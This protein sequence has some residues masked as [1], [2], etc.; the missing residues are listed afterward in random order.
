MLI[1]VLQRSVV[2]RARAP[3]PAVLKVLL[4][5]LLDLPPLAFLLGWWV[6]CSL[7]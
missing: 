1:V 7:V 3:L 5:T 6:F 4:P 2:L